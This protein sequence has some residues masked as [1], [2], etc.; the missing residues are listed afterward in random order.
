MPD[1]VDVSNNNGLNLNWVA[2]KQSGVKVAIAK[3]SE[4]NGGVHPG[5]TQNWPAIA[6]AGFDRRGAYHF[7]IASHTPTENA[8]AAAAALAGAGGLHG[9]DFVALDVE[10]PSLNAPWPLAAGAPSVDWTLACLTDLE[11]FTGRRPWLY[12][13]QGWLSGILHNDPRF[14]TYP[15]W[16]ANINPTPDSQLGTP[17]PFALRQYTWTAV[18]AG[19]ASQVDGSRFGPGYPDTLPTEEDMPLNATDLAHV[20]DIVRQELAAAV[21]GTATVPPTK[22]VVDVVKHYIPATADA[23]AKKLKP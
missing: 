21:G 11:R 23:V 3:C 18:V 7:A 10:R 14:S 19:I 6:A 2:V 15:L 20:R 17:W 5:F 8:Q 13:S 9:T 16:V 12:C 1:A 4:G 22:T